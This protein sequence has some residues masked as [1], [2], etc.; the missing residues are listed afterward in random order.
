MLALV[1]AS[2]AAGAGTVI[3]V[4]VTARLADS[5]AL[6]AW[7]DADGDLRALSPVRTE[8]LVGEVAFWVCTILAIASIVLG[9]IAIARR[10]GRGLGIAAIVVAV[11]APVL[12]VG[13]ALAALFAT[14]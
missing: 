14:S 7:L 10:S 11:V 1:L 12:V 8:V 13:A 2:I 3:A 5:G 9:V 6:A 4:I